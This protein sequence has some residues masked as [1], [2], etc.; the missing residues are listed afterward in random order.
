MKKRNL[1]LENLQ[2]QIETSKRSGVDNYVNIYDPIDFNDIDQLFKFLY[3]NFISYVS[4]STTSP[5]FFEIL[6]AFV[7]GG[8]VLKDIITTGS[9]HPDSE[10]KTVYALL[11]THPNL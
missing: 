11:L 10:E 9:P 4:I 3:R 8:Y 2:K 6:N 1:L 7:R 5:D